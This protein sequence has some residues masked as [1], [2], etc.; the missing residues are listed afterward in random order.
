MNK[1]NIKSLIVKQ[2]NRNPNSKDS[3]A[4]RLNYII[5]KRQ[6]TAKEV[7]ALTEDKSWGLKPISPATISLYINGKSAPN[8]SY[9]RRLAKVLNVD[10]SW[11]ACDLPYEWINRP[12]QSPDVTELIEIY[13]RL[14]PKKQ[15]LIMETARIAIAAMQNTTDKY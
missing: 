2:E 14:S 10:P 6:Y 4:F 13:G 8:I 3:I 12:Q 11:L 1:D 5:K 9:I 15:K 7:A